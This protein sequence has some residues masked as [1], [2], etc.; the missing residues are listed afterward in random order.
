MVRRDGR[1]LNTP[2]TVTTTTISGAAGDNSTYVIRTR[3]AGVITDATCVRGAN[4][5]PTPTPT[6][7][8]QNP[9]VVNPGPDDVELIWDPSFASVNVRRNGSWVANAS[10]SISI[11]VSGSANDTFQLII[12]PGGVRTTIAC[13]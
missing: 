9:C 8:P 6:P 4:P 10:G 2:G 3:P 13:V 12:R 7:T 1:W 11:I 5:A